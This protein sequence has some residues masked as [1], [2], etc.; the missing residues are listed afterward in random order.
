MRSLFLL[1]IFICT[2]FIAER[3]RITFIE[4]YLSSHV[5]T[6]TH[7]AYEI[8]QRT[9]MSDRQGTLCA[10]RNNST[11]KPLQK[12]PS[13]NLLP[14]SQSLCVGLKTKGLTQM[15]CSHKTVFAHMSGFIRNKC[16]SRMFV[17]FCH[18][19]WRFNSSSDK[20]L[21]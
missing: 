5:K 21:N 7:F 3:E 15:L 2:H 8:P 10:F 9:P 12:N 18:W 16:D 4:W 6:L 11:F 20:L 17:H 19:C 13:S 1:Y 14:C